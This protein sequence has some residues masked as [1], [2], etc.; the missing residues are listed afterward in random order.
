[1]D[2]GAHAAL[3]AQERTA[4]MSQVASP[5]QIDIPSM[6]QSSPG[7]QGP[8]LDDPTQRPDEPVTQGVDIGAGDGPEALG[9][10]PG[11]QKPD[12]YMTQTLSSL[13]ASDMTG[14]LAKL[15]L[16]AQQTGA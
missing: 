14:Q 16:M 10:Q 1:M 15:F 9:L 13:S 5:P 2:Y 3:L 8:A 4:P 7:Y 6:A 11:A 12:G